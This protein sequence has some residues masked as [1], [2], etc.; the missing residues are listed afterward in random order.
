MTDG[1]SGEGEQVFLVPCHPANFE[2][3][4]SSTVDLGDYEDRPDALVEAGDVRLA[5]AGDGTRSVESFGRMAPGD[6]LLF[7]RDGAYVGVGR[8]GLTFEDEDEWVAGTFWEDESTT[9]V[10]TVEDFAPIEVDRTVVNHLLEYSSSYVP[11]GLMRVAPD[12]LPAST[13][14]IELAIKRFDE[15]QG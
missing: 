12:R 3:T 2:R 10:Y 15:R 14:A 4:V 6:L 1:E 13:R 5:G 9:H 8:V 7:Y 11:A